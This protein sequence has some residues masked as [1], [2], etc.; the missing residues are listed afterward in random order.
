[1]TLDDYAEFQKCMAIISETYSK[2]TSSAKLDIWWSIFASYDVS[3]FEQS[4]FKH[5]TDPSKG[6][7]EPKPA[8]ILRYMPK[9]EK[10]TLV[11]EENLKLLRNKETQDLIDKYHPDTGSY[12]KTNITN[13]DNLK[14][15]K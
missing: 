14:V 4:I 9:P 2:P 12:F 13:A 10:P 8:D 6:T 3:D 11:I 15:E 1:M 5:V 7:F